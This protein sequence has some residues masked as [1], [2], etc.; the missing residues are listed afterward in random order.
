MEAKQL[1]DMT[2]LLEK[3]SGM[4]IDDLTAFVRTAADEEEEGAPRC[5]LLQGL[6]L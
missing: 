5:A 4:D 3:A 2:E 1:E 6:G